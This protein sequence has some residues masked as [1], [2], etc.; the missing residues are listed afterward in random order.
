M[1]IFRINPQRRFRSNFIF[2]ATHETQRLN[3]AAKHEIPNTAT[4]FCYE[5]PC[6]SHSQGAYRRFFEYRFSP[7]LLVS[8]SC[9]LCYYTL[10]TNCT[11]YNISTMYNVQ[12]CKLIIQ[13]LIQSPII[14]F[15]MNAVNMSDFVPSPPNATPI[16]NTR[17]DG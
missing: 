8:S 16:K 3:V 11:S 10:T 2:I 6:I 17:C 4:D 7:R 14:V 13:D 15:I 5:L 9:F 1:K 12:C